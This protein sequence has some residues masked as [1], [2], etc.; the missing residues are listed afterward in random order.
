MYLFFASFFADVWISYSEV[1]LTCIVW[2][3]IGLS[4]LSPVFFADSL[5]RAHRVGNVYQWGRAH[6]LEKQGHSR[7]AL[8]FGGLT[9]STVFLALGLVLL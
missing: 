5:Y 2:A 8:L 1:F 4:I 9:L 6:H 3:V 7:D